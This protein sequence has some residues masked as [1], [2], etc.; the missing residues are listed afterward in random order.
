[1]DIS[2]VV[3]TKNSQETLEVVLRRLKGLVKEIVVVDGGSRDN[4]VEIAKK[5]ADKILF[6]EGKGLG[7][8][9]ELGRKNCSCEYIM[10]VDSDALVNPKF[11]DIASKLMDSDDSIGA[12]SC[13][14]VPLIKK[15][16]LNPIEKF[17]CWNIS[18]NIH[19]NLPEY[20][21]PVEAL[22]CTITLYRAKALEVAGGFD[23][24]MRLA[25]EDSAISHRLREAGYKLFYAPKIR[26]IHLERATH[27][28]VNRKYGKAWKCY[29]KYYPT[30]ANLRRIYATLA[31][32]IP[33]IPFLYWIYR[34]TKLY[35]HTSLRKEIICLSLMETWRHI[36]RLIGLM[37]L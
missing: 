21:Q 27:F 22:P 2:A 17:Q 23:Y 10:T 11:V 36:E 25:R 16:S 7:Y 13:K 9:R 18:A 24:R 20:P 28:K 6:D 12:V 5:Y 26:S 34:Y 31:H 37:G 35:L 29:R 32:I 33:C 1:M 30:Y 8:A 4:T 14:V 3:L 15:N 19:L